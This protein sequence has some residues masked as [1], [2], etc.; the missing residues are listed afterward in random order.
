MQGEARRDTERQEGA[1]RHAE[2]PGGGRRQRPVLSGATYHWCSRA[3]APRP[4]EHTSERG[5]CPGRLAG[6]DPSPMLAAVCRSPR[7]PLPAPPRP[8]THPVPPVRN[9]S[10]VPSGA[11]ELR[12]DTTAR[13]S[14]MYRTWWGDR[15][16]KAGGRGRLGPGDGRPGSWQQGLQVLA[17]LCVAAR[18]WLACLR[19][20]QAQRPR[21]GAHQQRLPRRGGAMLV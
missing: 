3:H 6:P 14:L 8:A 15:Q 5:C 13:L 19:D 11:S 10:L 16:G 18:V 1:S 2:Q 20:L 9:A 12:P 4:P 17:R 7:P 21:P